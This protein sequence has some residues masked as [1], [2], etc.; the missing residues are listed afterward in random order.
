MNARA[1]APDLTVVFTESHLP[2]SGTGG[3]RCPGYGHYERKPRQP[4][5]LDRRPKVRFRGQVKSLLV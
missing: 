2:G 1:W 5:V 3:V 4:R